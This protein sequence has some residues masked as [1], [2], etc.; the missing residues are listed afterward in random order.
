MSAPIKRFL[1]YAGIL[2]PVWLSAACVSSFTY[3]WVSSCASSTLLGFTLGVD[4]LSSSS[5]AGLFVVSTGS[6]FIAASFGPSTASRVYFSV[7]V[8]S[9]L[10]LLVSVLLLTI[11][12][13]G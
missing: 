13:L 7:S 1:E 6:S 3:L 9:R 2:G 12:V 11:S 10:V 5:R 8:V 4:R